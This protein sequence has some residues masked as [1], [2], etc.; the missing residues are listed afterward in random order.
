MS[1]KIILLFTLSLFVL[2]QFSFNKK[3]AEENKTER[4][5]KTK[6]LVVFVIDG[7]R[8]TE[9]FGDSSYTLI[10][11]LGKD[12]KK[13]GVLYTHFMNNGVTNTTPG[14]TAIMTGVYQKLTNDGK[15]LP[16]N[17][18]FMQ[19]Y[20]KASNADK[21]DA[22]V[23]SSKGK[24]QVLSNTKNK[25]WWNKY[26]PNVYC[27]LNGNGVDYGG[28]AGTWR[29]ME[30][31]FTVGSPKLTLI[32]LLAADANAHQGDWE[33]YKNGIK[34]CDD[35]L[36]K[37]WNLIQSNPKMR[38]QTALLVTND[39]GRHLDGHKDAFKSHGD[40]CYGCRHISLL[41]IGPDFKKNVTLDTPGELIDISKTISEMFHFDMPSSKGRVLTELFVD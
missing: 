4:S 9:T 36:Y 13:E 7:P 10:P 28:D 22:W 33:G 40:K 15:H 32:N 37:F 23:L 25:V 2:A 14:H 31:I 12:M 11:H 1:K 16:K 34:A 21:S 35:Y 24:L 6:Y 20:L 17:P 38:N 29:K 8:Y 39:H 41:A 26:I 19:Y 30:E 5:Y 27:G 3:T 18:S